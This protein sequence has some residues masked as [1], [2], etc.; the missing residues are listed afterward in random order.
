MQPAVCVHLVWRGGGQQEA[1]LR[2]VAMALL[3]S[4][5]APQ[6]FATLAAL[7]GGQAP[8]SASQ[9]AALLRSDP[10]FVHG[11]G[12]DGVALDL[13]AVVQSGK[14]QLGRLVAAVYP[15]ASTPTHLLKHDLLLY[16]IHEAAEREGFAIPLE[17]AGEAGGGGAAS[18]RQ[19]RACRRDPRD[20][21]L[22]CPGVRRGY[23]PVA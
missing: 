19:R 16:M 21:V 2:H 15:R 1:L 11:P 17:A 14:Q 3:R 13:P 5:N 10:H 22:R 6:S 4:G 12:A 23:L 9:L 20:P 8:G 18:S 7:G